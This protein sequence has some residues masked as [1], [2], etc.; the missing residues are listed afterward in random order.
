M[1]NIFCTKKLEPFVKIDNI[2]QETLN[3]WNAHLVYFDGKKC[4][5]FIDKKTLYSIFIANIVKKDLENIENLFFNSLIQQLK[6]DKIYKPEMNNYLIENFQTIKFYKT[7]NDQ[8]TLGTLR[9]NLNHLKSHCKYKDN[10]LLAALEFAKFSMNE[11]PIG[12]RN[13]YNAKNLM[14]EELK[15]H[16]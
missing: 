4:L 13:F 7:Y 8:K 14:E 6:N 12:I 15:K 10:K 16:T 9:D 1:V 2:I 5:Y 3:Q 11:I